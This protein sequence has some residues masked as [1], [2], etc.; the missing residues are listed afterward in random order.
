MS[1]TEAVRKQLEGWRTELLSRARRIDA[2]L[3]RDE[4]VPADFAEQATELENLD[5]LFALDREGKQKLA[6][7]NAALDRIENGDYGMC[8]RCG[9]AIGEARL[10]ALPTTETCMPCASADA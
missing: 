4:P 9:D 8:T 1:D 5:V 6:Q 10:E 7:I 2:H 3:H